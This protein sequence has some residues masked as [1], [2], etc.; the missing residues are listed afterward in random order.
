M[1]MTLIVQNSTQNKDGT[2]H[3]D[4]DVQNL[5]Q[6]HDW[7]PWDRPRV[8]LARTG[9]HEGWL[10][11]DCLG[12]KIGHVCKTLEDSEDSE[13]M[14]YNRSAAVSICADVLWDELWE[15]VNSGLDRILGFGRSQDEIVAMICCSWNGFQGLY[16]Y[17]EVLVK[18]GGVVGGLFEG[19]IK[20]LKTAMVA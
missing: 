17:L 1:S 11:L 7:N 20:A 6:W 2:L 4:E 16:E 15:N 10:L 5:A 3:E 19:K 12:T 14:G 13:L 8:T 9:C 18:Q